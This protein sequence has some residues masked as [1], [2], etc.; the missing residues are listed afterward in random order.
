MRERKGDLRETVFVAYREN[1]DVK[2]GFIAIAILGSWS[3]FSCSSFK[4]SE[5]GEKASNECAEY[6]YYGF[7]RYA[8]FVRYSFEKFIFSSIEIDG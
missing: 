2:H 4:R 5:I 7:S 8:C 3:K 6:V 1:V